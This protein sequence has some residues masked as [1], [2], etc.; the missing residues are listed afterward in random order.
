MQPPEGEAF[1]STGVFRDVDA[2]SA[3][4]VTFGW[5]PA[6]PDDQETLAELAFRAIGG[7]TAVH[8]RQGPFR[9]QARRALHHDGW[10]ASL[11]KLGETPPSSGESIER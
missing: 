2:P 1:D 11:E 10:T 8:V 3:V 6:D 9:T 5:E 7:S 4:G